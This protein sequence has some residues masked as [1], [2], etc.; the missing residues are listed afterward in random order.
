MAGYLEGGD[1]GS[2]AK[3]GAITGIIAFLPLVLLIG[4]ALLLVPVMSTAGL[5]IQ[6]SLWVA[7]VFILLFAAVYVVGLGIVGGVLGVYVK[8]EI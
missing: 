7:V 5:G 4:I 6:L 3:V 8:E 1:Y 2:G